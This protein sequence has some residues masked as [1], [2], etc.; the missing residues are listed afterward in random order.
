MEPQMNGSGPPPSSPP[1]GPGGPPP[2]PGGQGA[3]PAAQA[4]QMIEKG[5]ATMAQMIKA[6]GPQVN[7]ED[8]KLFQ[9]ALQ[10]TQA[11]IQGITA[12]AQPQ[13]PP[14]QGRPQPGGPMPMNANKNATP[15]A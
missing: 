8:I 10:A 11:F 3:S 4:I 1:G 7:P 13:P 2:G 15:A 9:M 5:Y 14:G 6:A 12:P